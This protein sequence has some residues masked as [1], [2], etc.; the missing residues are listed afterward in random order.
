M[1]A[2]IVR[3][4]LA[5]GAAVWGT[6]LDKFPSYQ[7]DG[8]WPSLGVIDFLTEPLRQRTKF[9]PFEHDILRYSAAY[10]GELLHQVWET[11]GIESRLEDSSQGIRIVVA[12]SPQT[13]PI[14]IKLEHELGRQLAILP[15]S[16]SFKHNHPVLVPGFRQLVPR[17][18]LGIALGE[19]ISIEGAMDSAV[20]TQLSKLRSTVLGE[21][22]KQCAQWFSR[23]APDDTLAQLP[24]LYTAILYSPAVAREEWPVLNGVEQLVAFKAEYNIP[25]KRMTE[26]AIRLA[27]SPEELI[28]HVGFAYAVAMCSGPLP[29]ELLSIAQSKGTYGALLRYAAERVR[30][31]LGCGSD[32]IDAESLKGDELGRIEVEIEAGL[33]PWI[34]LRPERL[35][36]VSKDEA[37]RTLLRACRAF[38]IGAALAAADVLAERN[39]SDI[40][41]AVQRTY[42][43]L[44]M[45]EP[46]AAQAELERVRSISVRGIHAR[47]ENLA[48]VLALSSGNYIE[49]ERCFADARVAAAAEPWLFAEIA[50]SCGWAQVCQGRIREALGSFEDALQSRP[51]HLL[52]EMNLISCLLTLN[53]VE[54]AERHLEQL[55][56]R[57]PADRHVF[58]GLARGIIARRYP[59][60][61]AAEN[62]R[63]LSEAA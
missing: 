33:F 9:Y 60:Q 15:D 7:L 26:L 1:I 25:A 23:V 39:P 24:E 62:E 4:E 13:P 8:S 31:R 29:S 19:S 10:V 54:E 18:A 5:R 42:L 30:E 40:D 47:C 50:N 63:P 12:G 20:R 53:L 17:W 58:V 41:F 6:E 11:A 46:A 51:G 56:L 32:W 35:L 37:L 61:I 27:C 16:L 52:A 57:G 28:S 21:L 44:L 55:L 2:E 48:G 36:E 59:D 22:A 3:E 43:Y 34:A 49:S 14:H 45:Q 38:D